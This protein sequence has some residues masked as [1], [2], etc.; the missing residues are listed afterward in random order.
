MP[1]VTSD[2]STV[3]A[4]R[5]IVIAMTNYRG[6]RLDLELE[7]V[8]Q[9]SV[10]IIGGEVNVTASAGAGGPVRLEVDVLRG[11]EVEVDLRSDGTLVVEHQPP[12]TIGN[13]L[14]G[15]LS[16]KA[17][18]AVV[19]PEDTEVRVR[20]VSGDAFV[21]GVAAGTSVSTVSGRITAT[22]LDGDVSLKSV[23]GDLEVQGVG[24]VVHANSVSGDLTISGGDPEE[25]TARAVSGDLTFDL[26]EVPDVDCTTVSGDVALRL[27]ADAGIDLDAITV[28]GRLETSFPDGDLDAGKRRLRGRI[29]GGGRRVAVRTT[30]GDMILLRRSDERATTGRGLDR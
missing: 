27:P 6:D 24:G 1:A 2:P 20:T 14:N 30:S 29:G 18:V 23:S 15:N 5:Y 12:R 25:I 8:T 3:G 28:S 11:P 17:N 10:R 26:D 19:V 16:L 7:G 21:G 13:L 9:L 4:T 22:G